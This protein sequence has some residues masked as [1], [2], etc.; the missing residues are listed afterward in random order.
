MKAY[1]DDLLVK[2]EKPEQ[3]LSDLCESFAVL[4]RYQIKLNPSKCAF[5]VESGKFLEFMVSERGI[6]A[7]LK[8]VEAIV[9]CSPP[10]PPRNLHEVQ[11]L[12]GWVATLNRFTTRSTDPCLSFFKVLRKAVVNE[13]TFADLKKYL[14][15]PSLLNQTKS[16]E[17]LIL[18]LAVS[19]HSVSAVL[20]REMEQGNGPF[21]TRAKLSAKMKLGTHALKFWYSHW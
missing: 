21:T 14:A 9:A 17:D 2:S 18:Y 20:V 13:E 6:E 8:K 5:G 19:P 4:Q 11:R 16:S 1:V 3:H 12:D 10:T 15:H 7:N